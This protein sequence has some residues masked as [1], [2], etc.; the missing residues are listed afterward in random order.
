MDVIINLI[1]EER[2][3]FEG[4]NDSEKEL[5]MSMR[6]HHFTHKGAMDTVK[7]KKYPLLYDFYDSMMGLFNIPKRLFNGD[8]M[9]EAVQFI[10]DNCQDYNK[11]GYAIEYIPAESDF[12]Y[13]GESFSDTFYSI[14]EVEPWE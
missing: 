1:D 11:Q 6:N 3:E 14:R 7:A 4:L 8:L 9:E 10:T 13:N 12:E 2:K 5:Y